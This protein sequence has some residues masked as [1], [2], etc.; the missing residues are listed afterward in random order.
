[1]GNQPWFSQALEIIHMVLGHL[2]HWTHGL[3]IAKCAKTSAFNRTKPHSINKGQTRKVY[4]QFVKAVKSH[5][6]SKIKLS[7]GHCSV[8]CIFSV[9]LELAA[10]IHIH[11]LTH[12][13]NEL[14][15]ATHV[16]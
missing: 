9:T 15:C 10:D 1:M 3:H 16:C 7:V 8:L 11:I 13:L 4:F 5:Y 6:K 14:E 12:S 2:R